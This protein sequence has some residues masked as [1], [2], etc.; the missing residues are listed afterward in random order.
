MFMKLYRWS[1][2]GIAHGTATCSPCNLS[3]PER[4][5]F[6]CCNGRR[7][8]AVV[9][10]WTYGWSV[11]WSA[12]ID[13]GTIESGPTTRVEVY[14]S[15]IAPHSSHEQH[16]LICL[17]FTHRCPRQWS[18]QS[19]LLQEV[20]PWWANWSSGKSMTVSLWVLGKG[21]NRHRTNSR[22]GGHKTN[23][24]KWA[25]PPA[26]T[27]LADSLTEFLAQITRRVSTRMMDIY[28][29]K[30]RQQLKH[31]FCSAIYPSMVW[32]EIQALFIK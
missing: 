31:K 1:A 26:V 28:P 3:V 29:V 27:I 5:A 15:I 18:P 7:S 4:A 17:R 12:S 32:N 2:S 20:H 10:A 14:N 9:S 11:R 6:G 25:P 21:W 22:C 16:L 23:I 30:N 8:I 13:T 19:L 24:A